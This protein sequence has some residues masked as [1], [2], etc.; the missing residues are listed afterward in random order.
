MRLMVKSALG[1]TLGYLVLLALMAVYVERSLRALEDELSADTLRLL[2]REQANL[3]TERS[4]ETLRDPDAPSRRRLQER[5]QDLTLLSQVVTSLAVVD[6]TGRV[7][8]SEPLVAQASEPP[9]AALFPDPPQPRL[10]RRARSFLGGGD[11]TVLVPLSEGFEVIGYLRVGLHSNSVAAL[12]AQSRWRAVMLGPLALAGIGVLCALVQLQLSRRAA[13][14]AAALEGKPPAPE[15]IA[16]KD[17]FARALQSATR[18]KSDLDEAR[19]QSERRGV[20]VGALAHLLQVGVVLARQDLQLEYVSARALELCGCADEAG[21]R[22]AWGVLAPALRQAL[23]GPPAPAAQPGRGCLVEVR[24]GRSVQAELHRLEGAAD[25][26]LVVLSDPRALEFVENDRRLLRQL[27][28]LGRVYRT[29][30]HELRAPLGAVMLNLDVLQESAGGSGRWNERARRC[31]CVLRDELH[32][33]NRS[34][35]G[36]L[37]Q[38]VPEAS[39]HSFDLAGSLA[40]LVAFL[41]PQA[42]RQSVELEIRVRDRPLPVHG[43]PDRLRQAFL[44]VAVNAL[45]AMPRG[46]RLTL[47]ARRDGSRARIELHDTG[48]GIPAAA[49]ARVY[50][51]D[52]TTKDGGSG[53][54]LHVARAVVELHG[55]EIGV[56]SQPGCG[57][58]VFVVVPLASG[59]A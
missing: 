14:I 56:E 29:L 51:P 50:D 18:V 42:R 36:I 3:V 8:A 1:M 32:R 53:I 52:F 35:H 30:A 4:V 34:L 59:A 37:T 54:G 2:A 49:L 11:Y 25:D 22:E 46:G 20:Q 57:T 26:Q 27:D 6:K 58:D 5:L 39:P 33:L 43:Y 23:A 19:R 38:T 28:G 47:E 24:P 44:N 31:V 10:E 13:A 41:A 9:P 7:I 12:Y 16:A 21:F 55:G 17:E 48:P 45:E 40:D 15:V